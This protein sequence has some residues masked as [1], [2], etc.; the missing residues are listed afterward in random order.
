[1]KQMLECDYNMI[2]VF[3][4]VGLSYFLGAWIQR[5]LQTWKWWNKK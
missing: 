1:M 2:E 3:V 4:L 5:G